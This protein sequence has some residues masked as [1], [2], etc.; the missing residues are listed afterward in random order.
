MSAERKYIY[1]IIQQAEPKKFSFC[2]VGDAEVYTIGHQELA[3]VVSDTS[4]EEI[5]P[6]RKNVRAHT[7]VQDELLKSYT[8]LPMGFG[9]IAGSKSDVFKLLEKNYQSLASELKRLE[10]KIEVELKIFWDQ[11]AMLKELQSGSDE[12]TQMKARIKNASSSIEAQRLLVEAGKLVE[13]I[14]LDWKSKYADRVYSVL[15]ELAIDA[16]LN[17]PLGVKNILNA[18]F[19]IEKTRESDFQKEV[20]KLDSQYQGKVNFKYVGPLAPYSFVDLKLEPVS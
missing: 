5:D 8:L 13:G 16:R 6:T 12:L 3:A 2:G 14:A 11:E 7:L 1:G 9:M 4:F 20:Y 18:S 19:L 17:N 15:K 10:G